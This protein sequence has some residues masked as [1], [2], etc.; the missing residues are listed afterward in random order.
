MSASIWEGSQVIPSTAN[1][2]N[3]YLTE[4]FTVVSAGTNIFT[5]STFIY[6]PGTGSVDVYINGSHQRITSDFTETSNNQV[7]VMGLVIG[8]AVTIKGL[9]G[10]DGSQSAAASA[11]ASAASAAAALISQNAAAVSETQALAYKNSAFASASAANTSAINASNSAT[12]AATSANTI[13][14][15]ATALRYIFS[16][17]TADSDP[18][19]GNLRLDNATQNLATVIRAD[20]N[21][22]N[23][24]LLTSLLDSL[25]DST[26]IVSKGQFRLVKRDDITAWITFNLTSLASPV[27]YRNYSVLVTGSSAANPFAN[28]DPVVLIWERTGDKGDTG[29]PTLTRIPRAANTSLAVTNQGNMIVATASFTQTLDAAATLGAGWFVYYENTSTGNVTFDPNG[30]ELIDGAATGILEPGMKILI[31]CTGTAFN[32]ERY[33]PKVTKFLTSG[34]SG[35][36]PLGVR[37]ATTTQCGAGGGGARSNDGTAV[38]VAGNGGAGAKKQWQVSPNSAYT[39]AIGAAGIGATV[40]NTAGGAGGNTTF[41]VSATTVTTNGGTG[42]TASITVFLQARNTATNGDINIDSA[43]GHCWRGATSNDHSIGGDGPFGFGF[44][45]AFN[46]S[47]STNVNP[48]GNGSGGASKTTTLNGQTGTAGIIQLEY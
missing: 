44:G 20:L 41:T 46:G 37:E 2:D 16:T 4:E 33:G 14:G 3:S 40:D 27:G 34:T 17:T 21:D 43:I 25:D 48:S 5:L 10:G 1:A 19:S 7:T 28:L 35:T 42:G 45:G 31:T 8:D 47:N 29:N 22:A 32:C 12:A 6:E 26:S 9:I 36:F 13:N 11:A 18:G 24:T 15:G 38:G 30:A 39:Y 23:G